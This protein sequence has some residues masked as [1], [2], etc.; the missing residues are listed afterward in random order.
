MDLQTFRNHFKERLSSKYSPSEID[1][2]LRVLIEDVTSY[3][4]I[5]LLAQ[6]ALQMDAEQSAEL[7][8]SLSELQTGKPLHYVLKKAWFAGM[9]LEVGPG[10]L[11]PRPETEELIHLMV[12]QQEDRKNRPLEILDIG[13]GSG[14][15]A[16]ALA[17]HFQ[18]A[19]VHAWDKSADALA[20]A[21]RN[22]DRTK[23]AV[24][25]QEVDVL[26]WR[27]QPLKSWDLIV[28]NPPYI[29]QRERPEMEAHV[30]DYEPEM[31]L[32]VE[33]DRPLLFYETITELAVERSNANG[34]LYFE[35]NASFAAEM[36]N[37]VHQAGFVDVKIHDDMQGLPRMLSARKP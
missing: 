7:E 5:E 26:D 3:R 22:A 32:F 14:C 37:L 10:V 28:S 29:R 18:Q 2:M 31:A 30:L 8:R 16:L 1:S 36:F 15:I 25:F 9:D 23:L 24:S 21:K 6:P 33:D 19:R 27:Q 13:T 35:I 20:I 34:R 12:R 11:I 17:K 4:W